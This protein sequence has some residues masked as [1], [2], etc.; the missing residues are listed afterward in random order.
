MGFRAPCSHSSFP[1][2]H[3]GYVCAQHVAVRKL[4]LLPCYLCHRS[5]VSAAQRIFPEVV[6]RAVLLPLHGCK[7]SSSVDTGCVFLRAQNGAP[8]FPIL[9]HTAFHQPRDI[10]GNGRRVVLVLA[11]YTLAEGRT[12]LFHSFPP[13]FGDFSRI[14]LSRGCLADPRHPLWSSVSA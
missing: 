10:H 1:L 4:R 11:Q 14:P 2:A 13:L 8:H 12:L 9:V 6:A 7:D 3:L 5:T